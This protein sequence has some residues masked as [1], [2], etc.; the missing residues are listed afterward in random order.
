MNELIDKTHF[1]TYD[2]LKHTLNVPKKELREAL[3]KRNHDRH[4]KLSQTRPYMNRIF[5]PV[6]GCYFHDLLQQTNDKPNDECAL[7]LIIFTAIP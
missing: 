4:L 6:I 1:K 2:K 5:D 7:S 3:K